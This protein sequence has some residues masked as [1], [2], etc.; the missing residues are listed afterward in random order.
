MRSRYR[1]GSKT[2]GELRCRGKS[3]GSCKMIRGKKV[4]E[5]DYRQHSGVE[6]IRKVLGAGHTIYSP[7]EVRED[8][9]N[10]CLPTGICFSQ[11]FPENG[12]M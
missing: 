7:R 12:V 9:G 10:A 6:R 8:L 2:H 11:R 5:A 1:L 3:C 4:L